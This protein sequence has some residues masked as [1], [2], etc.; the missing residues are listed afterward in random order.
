MRI[1]VGNL[2]D[3]YGTLDGAALSRFAAE[4]PAGVI[5]ELDL[6]RARFIGAFFTLRLLMCLNQPR[7]IQVSGANGSAVADWVRQPKAVA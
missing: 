4:V 6:G 1:A 3:E 7:E 5:V 2:I